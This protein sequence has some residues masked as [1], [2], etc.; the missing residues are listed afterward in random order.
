MC[1]PYLGQP[2]AG[3]SWEHCGPQTHPHDLAGTEDYHT[4]PDLQ[5]TQI[6]FRTKPT[7]NKPHNLRD[8]DTDVA[9]VSSRQIKGLRKKGYIR[10]WEQINGMRCACVQSTTHLVMP[11]VPGQSGRSGISGPLGC[12]TGIGEHQTPGENWTTERGQK[13][14]GNF[15]SGV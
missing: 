13:Y 7:I 8:G 10:V 6:H 4:S 14:Y 15:T 9:K 2:P 5:H 12:R 11:A 1:E 3:V